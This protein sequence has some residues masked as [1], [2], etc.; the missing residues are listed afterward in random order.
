MNVVRNTLIALLFCSSTATAA[1]ASESSIKQLLAVT[2]VQKL[3]DDMRVQFDSLMNNAVQQAL[4]GNTP[5]P[6]QQQATNNMKNR[7]VALMKGELAWE[8]IEPMYLRLYK[9]S[10]SEEEIGSML[11]FYRT[12]GG[13]ALI[14]KMPELMQKTMLEIQMMLSGAT[15][16]M[17]KIQ[18]DF[19][20]EIMA[21]SK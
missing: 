19:I 10:F 9:E 17:Q 12:P 4:K 21:A 11:S 7:M 14:N 15:P 5:T 13:Q 3:L 1:P 18:Q 2:Q 20:A 8:K 16:Q 6:R